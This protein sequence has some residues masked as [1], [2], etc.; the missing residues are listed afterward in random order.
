MSWGKNWVIPEKVSPW[1]K[2][3]FKSLLNAYISVLLAA[4]KKSSKM[5]DMEKRE[6]YSRG[7]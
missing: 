2:L 4:L 3:K 6:E 5:K 1:K 7:V